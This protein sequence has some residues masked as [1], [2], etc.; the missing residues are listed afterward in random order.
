MTFELLA[1]LPALRQPTGSAGRRSGALAPLRP[2]PLAK[3][4]K[5]RGGPF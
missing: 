3:R 2:V 4:L 1:D 5:P